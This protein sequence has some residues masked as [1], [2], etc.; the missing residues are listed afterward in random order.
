MTQITTENVADQ[1]AH[2]QNGRPVTYKEVTTEDLI[3]NA[4]RYYSAEARAELSRRK[5]KWTDYL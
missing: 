5:I 3:V 2:W 1:I 4:I